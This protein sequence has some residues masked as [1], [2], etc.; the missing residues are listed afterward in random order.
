[1][2]GI[3]D[4]SSGLAFWQDTV[5]RKLAHAFEYLVLFF[6][7]DQ[8]FGRGK[9]G[10]AAAFAVLFAVSDEFHQSFVPGRAFAV[11]DIGIDSLGVA[12]GYFFG[13]QKVGT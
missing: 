12:I 7:T 6:L 8:V 1:M 9:R 2:S 10:W 3:P 13:K 4:L 5:L 11:Y